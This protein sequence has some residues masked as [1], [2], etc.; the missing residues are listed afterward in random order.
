MERAVEL[1]REQG[2]A[3][4]VPPVPY[5]FIAA[6]GAEAKTEAM[7]LARDLRARDLQVQVAFG[8]R[9]LKAQ[10]KAANTSNARWGVIIGSGELASD[11]FTVRD[12]GATIDAPPEEKQQAVL[13]TELVDWLVARAE[14]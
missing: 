6:L 9:S 7:L 14:R 3:I 1:L 5:V 8:E 2:V 13:R 4:P 10:M 12:L 11:A